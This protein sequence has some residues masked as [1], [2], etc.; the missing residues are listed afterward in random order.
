MANDHADKLD[1]AEVSALAKQV[2]RNQLSWQKAPSR[3]DD[4]IDAVTLPNYCSAASRILSR[5]HNKSMQGANNAGL[6]SM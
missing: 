2:I 1:C 6:R 3:L 5:H 4:M